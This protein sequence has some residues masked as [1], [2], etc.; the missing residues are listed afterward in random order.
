MS[1]ATLCQ[2]RNRTNDHGSRGLREVM[3]WAMGFDRQAEVLE[4]AHLRQAVAQELSS[5]AR[6]YSEEPAA[7]YQLD[8]AEPFS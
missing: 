1:G 3:N 4:A 6:K 2:T 7:M 8:P 5:T